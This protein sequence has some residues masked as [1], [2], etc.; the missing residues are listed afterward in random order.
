MTLGDDIQP[1]NAGFVGP[2]VEPGTVLSP[3]GVTFEYQAA[4]ALNVGD[5]VFLDSNGEAAKSATTADYQKFI[6][7]VVGGTKTYMRAITRKADVGIPAAAA[8]EKVIVCYF[9]KCYGIAAAAIA[10]GGLVTV[11]TTAGALDDAAGATQGQI[12]GTALEAAAAAADKVLVLV[13][14][15]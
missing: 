9:G 15:R 13:N 3:G 1:A 2:T 12:I 10:L 5:A 7:I 8:D 6:G 11:V 14:H 4:A